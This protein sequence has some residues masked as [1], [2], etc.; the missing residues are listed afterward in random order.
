MTVKFIGAF[1]VALAAGSTLRTIL[2]ERRRKERLLQRMAAALDTLA[3]EI[4]WKHSPIP[5]ILTTLEKDVVV[6]VYFKNIKK[7]LN[8]KIPLQFAWDNGFSAFPLAEEVLLNIDLSGD[9]A[10]MVSSLERG[11]ELLRQMLEERK[12]QR[13]EQTKLCTAAA[14]SIAGG[15][16]L[17]LL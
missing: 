6:G 9:E 7:N 8:R 4:R 13:P 5:D 2:I 17:L 10:Q 15:L 14:L 16:I 1:C 12:R 3:R 11:A